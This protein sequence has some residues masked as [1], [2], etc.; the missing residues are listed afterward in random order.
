MSDQKNKLIPV[1]HALE[2]ARDWAGSLA[3]E[4]VDDLDIAESSKGMYRRSIG[5]FLGW[6]MESGVVNPT[7][8][9]ILRFKKSLENLEANT[10]ANYM[11]V[12][13][14]FFIWTESRNLY[15]NQAKGIKAGKR[16]KGFRK[17]ALTADQAL[18]LLRSIG[19][20]NFQGKRD[21]AIVN[22]LVRTG[23]RVNEV[24]EAD[25]DDIGFHDGE[26]VLWIKGKG[27][28]AKDAF[29]VL[30]SETLEPIKSYLNDR[31]EKVAGAPLFCSL[32]DRNRGK[33]LTPRSLSR[34]VKERLK[35]AGLGNP[36]LTAHSLRHTAV[37][38]A[39]KG[40]A[41]LQEVQAMARHENV[42]T[43]M[44]Y[45]QNLDRIRNSAERKIGSVLSVEDLNKS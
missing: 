33:R 37:T 26:Q 31:V 27:R 15:P 1:S 36:R 20:E 23:L 35:L 43:T 32:S 14:R 17:D 44:V 25:I 16:P 10:V 38:L 8:L 28:T 34:L 11:A 30:L 6:M 29:V 7:R 19:T 24:T 22:L 45:A 41:S 39:L 5:R 40:G 13:Q 2:P 4:F 42:T 18:S 21:F 3:K 12:V 9:D